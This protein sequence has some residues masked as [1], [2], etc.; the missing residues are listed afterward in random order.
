MAELRHDPLANRWTIISENRGRRPNGFRSPELRKTDPD[1]CP[2]CPGK[3]SETPPEIF[4]VRPDSSAPD[5]PDWSVRVIPNRFPALEKSGEIHPAQPA[6]LGMRM[7]GWGVHEL[8]VDSPAHDDGFDRLPVDQIAVT[9][10]VWKDRM[11]ALQED[12][13]I[14]YVQVFKNHGEAAG[15][16]LS[17]PHTQILAMPILPSRIRREI[18]SFRVHQEREGSCLVCDLIR[19]EEGSGD[20]LVLAEEK[21]LAWI[22]YASRFPFEVLV[23]PREHL[24]SFADAG[25]ATVGQLAKTLKGVFE[26]YRASLLD[27]A[28]NLFLHTIPNPRF[29]VPGEGVDS[30]SAAGPYH[31]H[32][33]ILPRL[34]GIGGFEWSTGIH[35]NPMPPEA[36]ARAL[37]GDS[38]RLIGNS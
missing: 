38:T 24:P 29:T 14:R 32:I 2:F 17:H 27:P 33:E 18:E 6:G 13:R 19:Q 20:R 15:A 9:L 36:A 4:A 30:S 7:D 8:V 25:A 35:I 26:L 37:R 22:P 28:Y 11:R 5:T 16:S 23:A 12:P 31:W 34:T 3:E 1:S 10:E 21:F